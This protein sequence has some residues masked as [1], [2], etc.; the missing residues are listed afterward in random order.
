MKIGRMDE[1]ILIQKNEVHVD[2]IG[3]HRNSW[4]DYYS[5]SA[6]PSTYSVD[7]TEG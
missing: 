7:E 4:T 5:C 2:A 3:N 6:Y 1:R